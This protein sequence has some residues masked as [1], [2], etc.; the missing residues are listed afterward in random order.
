MERI[1][2]AEIARITHI[3]PSALKRY[4]AVP[5][6]REFFGVADDPPTYPVQNIPMFRRLKDLHDAGK[7]TPKSLPA[8]ASVLFGPDA[9][10]FAPTPGPALGTQIGLRSLVPSAQVPSAITPDQLEALMTRAYVA[11][12]VQTGNVTPP[13]LLTPQQAAKRLSC[14]PGS[15][16]RYV[17]PVRRGKYRASDVDAYINS[18]EPVPQIPSKAEPDV[19]K[20]SI[21]SARE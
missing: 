7:V 18:L 4:L 19:I 21:T 2:A 12:L 10:Q 1:S 5:A 15:V 11:A 20:Y 14:S 16:S 6:N 9:P 13:A 3:H 17:R 8:L